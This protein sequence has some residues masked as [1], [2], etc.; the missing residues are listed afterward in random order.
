MGFFKIMPIFLVLARLQPSSCPGRPLAGTCCARGAPPS[1]LICACTQG[2]NIMG[3]CKE[4]N[5]QTSKMAG[6]IVPVEITVYEVS[7]SCTVQL[8]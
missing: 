3:F 6:E 1:L 7:A 5:A 4:Y 8:V 2:V